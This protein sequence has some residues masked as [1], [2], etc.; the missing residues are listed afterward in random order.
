M[1]ALFAL[2]LE[3]VI[4]HNSEVFYLFNYDRMNALIKK[5]GKTKIFLCSQLGRG[6]TYLRDAEKQHTN[7]SGETL[8]ILAEELDTT[9]EY[10]TGLTDDPG[11]KKGTTFSGDVSEL[12]DLQREAWDAIR[13][14]DDDTL[15][16]FIT[17]AR[18]KAKE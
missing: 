2:F 13:A 3:F 11:K 14:M 12:S 6:K 7:I 1:Q 18:G 17:L 15:R 10:L 5:S 8:A 9:P 4:T 16:A